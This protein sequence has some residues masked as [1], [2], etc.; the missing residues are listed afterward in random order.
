MEHQ[1]GK[2]KRIHTKR[3]QLQQTNPTGGTQRIPYICHIKNGHTN[4]LKTKLLHNSTPLDLYAL[5]PAELTKETDIILQVEY[6]TPKR[7]TQ[8]DK[9]T[10][11]KGA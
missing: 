7:N 5:T 1:V 6:R 3:K 4:N 11:A 10:H 9:E 2:H 8:T